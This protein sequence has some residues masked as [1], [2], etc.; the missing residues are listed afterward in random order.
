[1]DYVIGSRSITGHNQREGKSK[2]IAISHNQPLFTY[3]KGLF[4]MDE[5]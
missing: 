4:F 5:K 1:M 3:G 2:L